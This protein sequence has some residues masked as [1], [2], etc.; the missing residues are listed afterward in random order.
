M[1]TRFFFK[2]NVPDEYVFDDVVI[3]LNH[4]SLHERLCKMIGDD[5]SKAFD[6]KVPHFNKA[7]EEW[8]EWHSEIL[9]KQM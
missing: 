5:V 4:E 8:L 3:G 2:W 9:K 7:I 1:I 6:K